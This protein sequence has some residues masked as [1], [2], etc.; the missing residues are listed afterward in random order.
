VD[1]A[2]LVER[3]ARDS[4]FVLQEQG[5]FARLPWAVAL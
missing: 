3:V 1:P 4:R 5:F 2:A